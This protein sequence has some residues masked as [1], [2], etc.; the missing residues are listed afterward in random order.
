MAMV[1]NLDV[2]DLETGQR[3]RRRNWGGKGLF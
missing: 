2:A 1:W 3:R